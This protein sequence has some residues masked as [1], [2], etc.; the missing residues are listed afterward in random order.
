MKKIAIVGYATSPFKPGI[1]DIHLGELVFNTVQEALKNT[2]MS[3]EDIETVVDASCDI[4]DGRSISNTFMIEPMGAFLKEE[5]KVEEDGAYATIYAYMRLLTGKFKTAMV[6]SHGKISESSP[7]TYSGTIADPFF[8]RPM[9]IT[10]LTSTALHVSTYYGHY[11]IDEKY[12]AMVAVKNLGNAKLNPRAHNKGDYTVEDVL[13]SEVLATPIKKLD[14]PP[15]TDGAAVI[16]LAVEGEAEKITDTPVWIRGVGFI[17]DG[18]YLGHRDLIELPSL[19]EAARRA[20]AAAGIKNPAE[21]IDIAEV[22]ESYSFNELMLYDGLGFCEKGEGWKLIEEG[23]TCRDGKLPVNV[24]GGALGAN[25]L[26]ARGLV[27]MIEV[28]TQLTGKAGE[29]QVK[30]DLKTGLVHS[31][32]GFCFQSNVV[33]ILS[34]EKG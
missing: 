2:G 22:Y 26:M 1:R 18:F 19:R 15:V 16:I 27:N 14:S 11:G 6:V 31:T 28:A 25:P 3:I 23:T 29:H 24:S 8:M 10:A 4:I 9:G 33:W 13:N 12:A 30:K 7:D 20:Y 5:A 34:N 17:N 21:E 32:S